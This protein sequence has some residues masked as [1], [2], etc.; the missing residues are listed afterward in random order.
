[1]L[2]SMSVEVICSIYVCYIMTIDSVRIFGFLINAHDIYFCSL[3][4]AKRHYVLGHPALSVGLKLVMG[5]AWL[6]F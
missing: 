1:M 3:A 5:S 4:A 6:C 2:R